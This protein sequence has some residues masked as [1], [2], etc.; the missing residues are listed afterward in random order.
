MDILTGQW[1][2]NEPLDF[3]RREILMITLEAAG[4]GIYEGTRMYSDS[5]FK[6]IGMNG[7]NIDSW[8]LHPGMF[9]LRTVFTYDEIMK[10]LHKIIKN[11]RD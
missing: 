7:I 3:K 11:K 4:V 1:I 10:E 6:Y 2:I 8:K 5:S 9:S